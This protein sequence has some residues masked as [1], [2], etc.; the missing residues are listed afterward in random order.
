MS[1]KKKADELF[2]RLL[3]LRLEADSRR[4]DGNRSGWV[5]IPDRAGWWLVILDW[6]HDSEIVEIDDDMFVTSDCYWQGCWAV[7]KGKG[8]GT[9]I[10]GQWL[11]LQKI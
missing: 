6:E 8:D 10:S 9:T 2:A 7:P 11:F 3:E 5:D 4:R 1:A